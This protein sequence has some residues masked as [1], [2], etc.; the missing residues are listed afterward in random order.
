MIIPRRKLIYPAGRTP[1]F[2]PNHVAVR[3]CQ[4]SNIWAVIARP[5]GNDSMYALNRASQP[6]TIYAGN[7]TTNGIDGT[8]GPCLLVPNGASDNEITFDGSSVGAVGQMTLASIC[9]FTV[10]G[11]CVASGS[12]ERTQPAN[13]YLQIGTSFATT[14]TALNCGAF[15]G[16]RNHNFNITCNNGEPYFVA[17]SGWMNGSDTVGAVNG[18]AV[19]LKTGQV[20]TDTFD[21]TLYNFSH[22]IFDYGGFPGCSLGIQWTV[23]RLQGRL[24]TMATIPT[25]LSIQDLLKWAED[26]WS[27]WFAENKIKIGPQG[28]Y[29]Q[30]DETIAD[31]A[32]LAKSGNNPSTDIFR[33]SLSD[34]PSGKTLAKP[35]QINYRYGGTSSTSQYLAVRLYEGSTLIAGWT[36]LDANSTYKNA[37]QTLTDAEFAAISNFNNLQLEFEASNI[38]TFPSGLTSS[39]LNRS[40][41]AGV[42]TAGAGGRTLNDA[43]LGTPVLVPG[44]DGVANHA[45]LFSPKASCNFSEN[46]GTFGLHLWLDTQVESFAMWIKVSDNTAQGLANRPRFWSYFDAASQLTV[47]NNTAIGA[48]AIGFSGGTLGGSEQSLC[49]PAGTL[50][51]DKWLLMVATR[52]AANVMKLYVGTQGGLFGEVTSPDTSNAITSL[53]SADWSYPAYADASAQPVCTLGPIFYWFGKKLTAAEALAVFQN[54]GG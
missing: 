54:P 53:G 42:D 18:I 10:G 48:G 11:V 39:W 28:L 51:N 3:G 1:R 40:A 13:L 26:P 52:D 4:S 49:A 22:T 32:D 20:Q 36:H 35:V 8:I 29:T 37:S 44:P 33:V 9:M 5:H 31:D 19:S 7:N 14:P 41:S 34:L 43:V 50:K 25:Y 6:P 16:S 12:G 17:C 23:P 46:A 38:Q 45:L 15:A 2:D 24:A 21:P 27:L 30:I 47:C